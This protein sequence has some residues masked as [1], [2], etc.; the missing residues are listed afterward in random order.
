MIR[1][2]GKRKESQFSYP[3]EEENDRSPLFSD[4]A[5]LG[6]RLFLNIGKPL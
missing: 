2:A 3:G 4:R 1:Q 5:V 6:D